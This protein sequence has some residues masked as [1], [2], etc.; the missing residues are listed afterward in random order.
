MFKIFNCFAFWKSV[1]F[2]ALKVR[3]PGMHMEC[4]DLKLRKRYIYMYIAQLLYLYCAYWKF[5]YISVRSL[6]AET[7]QYIDRCIIMTIIISYWIICILSLSNNR[8]VAW[9][10]A[11]L[12]IV[13]NR[14]VDTP[15]ICTG[16][17]NRSVSLG[18]RG[19]GCI[20]DSPRDS[21]FQRLNR[22]SN[23]DYQF[24][25]IDTSGSSKRERERAYTLAFIP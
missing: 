15:V 22:N 16:H 2:Y 20:I 19:G 12:I 7:I 6:L 24:I 17:R 21:H 25:L 11:I 18:W 23:S 4:K 1:A 8:Q 10:Y 5:Y 14:E 3:V 13:H 9:L